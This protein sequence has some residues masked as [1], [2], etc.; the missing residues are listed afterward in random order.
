MKNTGLIK[1]IT[2]FFLV[3]IGFPS[4]S[5]SASDSVTFAWEWDASQTSY[6]AGE[7]GEIAFYLYMRTGDD[8]N[9]DSDYP[10][11]EGIDNCSLN[12]D[13]YTCQATL[14]HDFEPGVSYFFSAA[15]YLRS[16]QTV[17]SSL[18]NEVAYVVED[19]DETVGEVEDDQEDENT[20]EVEDDKENDS[21][22]GDQAKSTETS[23]TSG[24][25]AASGGGGGCFVRGLCFFPFP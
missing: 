19:D 23:P 18:S 25:S 7:D 9:Y 2:L 6:A 15:A 13:L 11:L 20:D 17:I 3:V 21:D 1:Q 10:A 24:S 8:V 16:D 12:G 14:T 5:V 4:V 22:S